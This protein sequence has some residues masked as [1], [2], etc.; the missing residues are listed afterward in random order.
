MTKCFWF[1]ISNV[2]KYSNIAKYFCEFPNYYLKILVFSE[3][4]KFKIKIS[5]SVFNI[6][7][8]LPKNLFYFNPLQFPQKIYKYLTENLFLRARTVE[9]TIIEKYHK[10]L[11]VFWPKLSINRQS[12]TAFCKSLQSVHLLDISDKNDDLQTIFLTFL[13]LP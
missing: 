2:Q 3:E 13:K 6:L 1:I 10:K 7:C 8:I 9:R 5:V 11:L 12:T 4:Q